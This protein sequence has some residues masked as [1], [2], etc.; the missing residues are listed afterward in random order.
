MGCA[1][2]KQAVGGGSR[3]NVKPKASSGRH[4]KVVE[5]LDLPSTSAAP[6]DAA[7][8][9]SKKSRVESLEDSNVANDSK[10]K[11]KRGIT[12]GEG[13]GGGGGG[14]R[15]IPR[16]TEGEQVAAGWPP[17]LSAVAGESVKGWIPRKADSFEK[18]DKVKACYYHVRVSLLLC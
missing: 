4:T 18:I 17:W 14:L 13:G 5:R 12:R 3:P 6:S 8:T 16:Q 10:K 7:D 11:D 15:N 1:C 2:V 9:E